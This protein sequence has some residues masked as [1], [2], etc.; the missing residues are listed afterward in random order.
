MR[1]VAAAVPEQERALAASK[2]TQERRVEAPVFRTPHKTALLAGSRLHNWN[3][4][5]PDAGKISTNDSYT[6]A[7]RHVE[8]FPPY[9]SIELNCKEIAFH[10]AATETA[11]A[12]SG[13]GE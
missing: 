9:F 2:A 7:H 5:W 4:T 6:P 12:S 3:N 13:T 11:R 1:R 8:T 10:R